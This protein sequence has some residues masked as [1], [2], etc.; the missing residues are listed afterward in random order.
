VAHQAAHVTSFTGIG[1]F[2]AQLKPSLTR[3]YRAQGM[4]MLDAINQSQV[5]L[6]RERSPR[7][8]ID[9]LRSAAKRSMRGRDRIPALVRAPKL[10]MPGFDQPRSLG[11]LFDLIYTRDMWM[12][13]HDISSATGRAMTL[14]ARHDGRIVELVV[15]D[16]AEKAR[17]DFPN[18]SALLR[19]TG[20]AGGGYRIGAPGS[21]AATVTVDA[22]DFCVLTSGRN[23]ATDVVQ[24]GL[25]TMA[26]DHEL[27]ES[28]VA[29]FENRVLY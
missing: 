17:R 24:R 26:G 6:R 1:A 2:L 4:N 27:A 12:H 10:R 23:A 21:P 22:L 13:R 7:E 9:E 3:P 25:V 11:Y 20:P 15:L 29:Y 16:L 5:D 8:L 14:N 28:M 18:R 19:L